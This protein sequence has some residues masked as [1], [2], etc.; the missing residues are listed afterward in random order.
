MA[1]LSPGSANIASHA[2]GR[3]A[4]D[5]LLRIRIVLNYQVRVRGR[6]GVDV[7]ATWGM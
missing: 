1:S 6:G 2:G 5:S 3:A 7:R 4:V